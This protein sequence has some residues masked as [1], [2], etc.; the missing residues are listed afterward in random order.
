MFQP[1]IIF[2]FLGN[3]YFNRYFVHSK[4]RFYNLFRSTS[5]LNW[6]LLFNDNETEIQ[7]RVNTNNNSLMNMSWI[8]AYSLLISCLYNLQEE[9][10]KLWTKSSS[11]KILDHLFQ[12]LV[13]QLP[14]FIGK[15]TETTLK[16]SEIHWKSNASYMCLDSKTFIIYINNDRR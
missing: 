14:E 9:T 6:I 11:E 4:R 13:V 12:D 8:Q 3:R 5:W 7:T 15:T 1:L 16:W 10:A 2:C